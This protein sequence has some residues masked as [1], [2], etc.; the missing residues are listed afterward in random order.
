MIINEAF[1]HIR[2][3]KIITFKRKISTTKTLYNRSND[4][5]TKCLNCASTAVPHLVQ[6]SA[7]ILDSIIHKIFMYYKTHHI[8]GGNATLLKATHVKKGPIVSYL[9]Y[10]LSKDHLA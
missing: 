4:T 8:K 10:L 6:T 7:A 2:I 5:I 3:W 9:C 1:M